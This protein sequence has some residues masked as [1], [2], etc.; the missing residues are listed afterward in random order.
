[1]TE[2][3]DDDIIHKDKT[4]DIDEAMDDFIL[5]N[6]EHMIV[7]LNETIYFLCFNALTCLTAFQTSVPPLL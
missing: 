4:I 5:L 2:L 6:N 3:F 7:N 1:M